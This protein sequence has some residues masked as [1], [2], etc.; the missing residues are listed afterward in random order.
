VLSPDSGR[1]GAVPPELSTIEPLAV[2]RSATIVTPEGRREVSGLELPLLGAVAALAVAPAE[3]PERSPTVAAWVIASKLALELVARERVVPVI[4]REGGQLEARWAAALASSEDASQLMALAR[5]LPPAAHAVPAIGG[6]ELDVWAPEALLRAFIDAVV[7]ALLRSVR[8]APGAGRAR[9]G[10]KRAPAASVAWDQRWREALEGPERRFEPAGFAERSLGDDLERWS[11][12]ARGARDRLRACFRLELPPAERDEFTLGFL[13]Q[14]P[15]DPSLLLSASEV[16]QATGPQL[17][18]FGRA[19]RDPQESL[20][21]A[22]G[23]A[24]ALFPPL[25]RALHSKAPESLALDAATAWAFLGEGAAALGA[26]GFGVIVPGEL[27]AAGARRLRLRMRVGGKSKVAGAVAGSAALGLDELLAVDW[28]AVIGEQELDVRELAL[29]AEQKTPLVRFR[30]AWVAVDPSELADIRRRIAGGSGRIALREAMQAALAGETRQGALAVAVVA[31]GDFEA[32]LERLRQ[33]G[34]TDI[35]PPSSLNAVLRPY[36]RRGQSWLASMAS[37]GLGA[38]LADD[39]GLGKTVQLLAHLLRRQQQAPDD[40]R[41]ALLIAPTS[42]IG[43]WEREVERFAPSLSLTRHYGGGRAREQGDFPRAA[44]ALV[45]TSYGLLRRDAAL[46]ASVDW[47]AVALDEAQNIKNSASATARAAR[48]LR[49]AERF[50]LTGTPVENRLAELWSILDFTN[51]GLLGPLETFRREF[52]VPIERYGREAA[53]ARLRRIASPFVLRRL[54]SD[55]SIIADLPPKHEM[56]VVCT[57]SREQASL[58]KAVVDEELRRI[59]SA[60]GMERRGRVLALLTATKQI[61][62]HP[63]LY[64]SESGPLARRSGKLERLTEMLEEA[65]AAGDKA[66]VFTQ[67]REMGQRLVAH[68]RA[69]LGRDVAFLHGGTPKAARDEMVRRFQE[70]ELGPRVFVLSLKAGG[71]GLNLTAASHVFHYDRWWNPAVEDQATDRAYR[72]GQTR[73]VQVH[74]LVCAGSV[75]EKIEVLLDK[76]RDLAAQVVGSGEAWITELGADELRELFSLSSS[77][78]IIDAEDATEAGEALAKAA[79]AKRAVAKGAASSAASKTVSKAAASSRKP[80]PSRRRAE[81][82]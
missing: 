74:K 9:A 35:E 63:A 8:G 81:R 75:E 28:Q 48:G 64:L 45:L 2:A 14:A 5:C 51:P 47:S 55:P 21:E 82:P 80:A 58:Y 69:A 62:D 72:I 34:A 36:Q 71:T 25:G 31:S 70:D 7:D 49:A 79:G 12:P 30:G 52:A 43:N 24:A 41:P 78:A 38:C 67:Y 42:V 60:E 54:K 15:D 10:S 59:A 3:A 73:A 56:K 53:A 17:S 46:L 40:T 39:M 11:E 33:S 44:G 61:C 13:L 16:W 57:L 68:L 66:L 50:A 32:L 1:A 22:L 65:I 77:A 27:T 6:G 23:R 76:K 20:L 18:A 4:Q 26:A 37:L 29:L 19:F